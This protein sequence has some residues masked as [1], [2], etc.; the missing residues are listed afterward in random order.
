ML[1]SWASNGCIAGPTVT[2]G[3]HSSASSNSGTPV[4][5]GTGGLKN[6]ALAGA[7]V[8][9][10]VGGLAVA[11]VLLWWFLSGRNRRKRVSNQE[12]QLME[13]R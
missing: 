6:G 9:S 1:A 3:S 5:K 11:A 7:I 8:G 12:Y 13:V 2:S 10:V 4:A